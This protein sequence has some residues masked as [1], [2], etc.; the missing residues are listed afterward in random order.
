MMKE[1]SEDSKA[2]L[3]GSDKVDKKSNNDNSQQRVLAIYDRMIHG[4]RISKSD[5]IDKYQV[6]A[7]TIQRDMA[8]IRNML[9]KDSREWDSS[10]LRTVKLDRNTNEFYIDP[11]MKDLLKKEQAF[12]VLKMLMEC[13][14]LNKEELDE[15]VDKVIDCAVPKSESTSF[16][17]MLN[18]ELAN[19]SEPQ[20][21]QKLIKTVWW[22]QER[23][24]EKHIVSINYIRG[25]GKETKRNVIPVGLMFNE[26]Y[27]YLIGYIKS[28]AE[29]NKDISKRF[30]TV[31]RVDRITEYRDRKEVYSN[32]EVP[33]DKQLT[34]GEFRKR[35]QFMYGG[36]LRR[37]TLEVDSGS[38]EAVLDRLP[39][40]RI[41]KDMKAKIADRVVVEA[42][43][44]GPGFNMWVKGQEE[45]VR[46][47][48]DIPA[49]GKW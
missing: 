40:A 5:L 21:G 9:D 1:L 43:V 30:P 47:V 11:P 36:E 34:E 29:I 6:N 39:S 14:G 15:I 45:F 28:K 48:K 23:I 24:N 12:V 37:Y 22:L 13:R 27:F 18:Q 7:R 31:F 19:Y 35:V 38:V 25:D 8:V 41:R 10:K 3:N 33:H 46:V 26:F 4:Y 2:F 17:N 32:I 20:H 44:Y 49:L 42:E 16:K